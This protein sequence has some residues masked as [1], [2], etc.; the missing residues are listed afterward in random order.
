VKVE[1]QKELFMSIPAFHFSEAFVFGIHEKLAVE[2]STEA[3]HILKV[4]KPGTLLLTPKIGTGKR[5]TC[6]PSLVRNTIRQESFLKAFGKD[7]CGREHAIIRQ[8]GCLCLEE[9]A[10]GNT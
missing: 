4:R 9:E 1:S 6:G 3:Q 2:S 5:L 8:K 7:A 10:F